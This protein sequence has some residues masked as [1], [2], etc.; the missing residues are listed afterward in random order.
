MPKNGARVVQ[1][2]LSD[3]S[4]TSM[5]Q[6]MIGGDK[7]EPGVAV[8]K[9]VTL[10]KNIKLIVKLLK[11]FNDSVFSITYPEMDTQSA[12][13]ISYCDKLEALPI[14]LDLAK[15]VASDVVDAYILLKTA[16]PVTELLSTCKILI[17]S[18]T[19]LT[20]DVV[21]TGFINRIPGLSYYPMSFTDLNLKEVWIKPQTDDRIRKYIIEVLKVLFKKTHAIYGV[22][23]SADVDIEAFSKLIVES[24]TKVKKMIPRCDQAFDRIQK[25]V[26]LLKGNF[27]GYYKDFIQTQDPTVIMHNFVNDVANQDGVD[28]KTTFQFRKIIAFY[29]KQTE[30]KNITDPRVKKIFDILGSNMKILE[31]GNSNEVNRYAKEDEKADADNAKNTATADDGETSPQTE[32]ETSPQTECETSPPSEENKV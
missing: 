12:D 23:T 15:T 18:K 32:C 19:A 17:E 4:L 26:D 13:I 21:D 6:Q 30:G 1:K 8:P 11:S 16:D 3:D 24:I 25:S 29:K 9:Y 5:F 27:T 14:S 22:I 31:S 7:P 10:T 2:S 28:A 20:S